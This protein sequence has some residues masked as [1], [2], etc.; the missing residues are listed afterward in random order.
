MTSN[1]GRKDGNG[2]EVNPG[3]LWIAAFTRD[4]SAG[5]GPPPFHSLDLPSRGSFP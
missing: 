2:L 4:R 1:V 3:Q 5:R